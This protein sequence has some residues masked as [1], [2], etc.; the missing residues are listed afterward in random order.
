VLTYVILEAL[1]TKQAQAGSEVIKVG[2]LADYAYERVPQ[3]T[4]NIGRAK[5]IPQDVWRELSD[6]GAQG[7]A[8]GR[9]RRPGHPKGINARAET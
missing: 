4:S 2:S 6:R 5:T 8:D 7:C 9:S 3:I 1:D